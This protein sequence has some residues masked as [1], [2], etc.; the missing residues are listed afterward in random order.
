MRYEDGYRCRNRESCLEIS[1]AGLEIG[2]TGLE[3]GMFE[4]R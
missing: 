1:V 3:I 4:N 2:I